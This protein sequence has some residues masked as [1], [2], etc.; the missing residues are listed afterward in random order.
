MKR[1]AIASVLLAA[2]LVQVTWAPRL[3]V[4]GVFPNLALVAVI[5]ITWTAGVRKG[6]AW[7]CVA[8]LLLDLTA[9][10]PIGPHAVAL[11]AGA[12]ITG[13]W[14]RNLDR[15][16]VV[17]PV[18]AVAV[19]TIAYSFV[20]VVVDEVLGLPVPPFG[21]ALQLVIAACVYNAALMP[22]AM[23]VV[24]RL[25]APTTRPGVAV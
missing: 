6:M 12:Y 9:P 4:A 3:T 5:V 21:M 25:Q 7:A 14:I 2:V 10:G 18:L 22:I 23:W 15:E 17:H 8:G 20:L 19:S 11:L 13:F 16:S 1:L 24:R